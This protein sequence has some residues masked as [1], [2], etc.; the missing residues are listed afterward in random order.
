MFIDDSVI[1]A[2]LTRDALACLQDPDAIAGW[3]DARRTPTH[4]T[5]H[6]PRPTLVLTRNHEDWRP[7]DGAL[8]LDTTAGPVR[9]HATLTLRAVMRITARQ[10]L[11][12]GTQIWVHVE[13]APA[14]SARR[15]T[16]VL[17]K[18]IRRGLEHLLL[19]LDA[20]PDEQP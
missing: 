14:T 2:C 4:T 10:H 9:I 16:P 5:L 6:G 18:T 17:R 13:L 8:A 15:I 1:L 19:E 3:F 20:A 7:D 11:R 12:Q